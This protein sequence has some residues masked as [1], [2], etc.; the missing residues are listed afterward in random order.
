MQHILSYDDFT[1]AADDAIL[2]NYASYNNSAHYGDS[3]AT[4]Q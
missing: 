2:L 4:R 1:L 3:S